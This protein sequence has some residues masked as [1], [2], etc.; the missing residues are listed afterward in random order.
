MTRHSIEKMFFAGA[1]CALASIFV[2]CGSRMPKTLDGGSTTANIADQSANSSGAESLTNCDG[3][4]AAPTGNHRLLDGATMTL[5]D[6]K[7]MPQTFCDVLKSSGSRPEIPQPS[8]ESPR[9]AGR[10]FAH[11]A[12]RNATDT[13]TRLG[14]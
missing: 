13:T 6:L 11:L 14:S 9:S 8:G 7:G 2:G 3:T 12:S 5:L 10:T 1:L 4:E